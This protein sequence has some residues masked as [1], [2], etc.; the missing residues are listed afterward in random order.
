MLGL[1]L[2][3]IGPQDSRPQPFGPIVEYFKKKVYSKP[4]R[5]IES[6]KANLVKSAVSISLEVVRA[7]I[8]KFEKCVNTNGGHFE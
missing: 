1:S 3:K 5:N 6:L 2:L 4:H 8:D 7:V